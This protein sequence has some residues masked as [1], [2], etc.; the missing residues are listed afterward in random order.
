[1]RRS[2]PLILNIDI[3]ADAIIRSANSFGFMDGGI[4]AV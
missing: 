3:G 2:T 4:D 1:M